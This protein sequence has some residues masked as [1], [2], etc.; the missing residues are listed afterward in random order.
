MPEKWIDDA[1]QRY[2][3]DPRVNG[4]DG[5]EAFCEAVASTLPIKTA[6]QVLR[7]KALVERVRKYL[8]LLDEHMK[9]REALAALRQKGLR[10]LEHGGDLSELEQQ[11][12]SRLANELQRLAE[13]ADMARVSVDSV[14]ERMTEEG[15]Q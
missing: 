1:Y 3:S 7:L 11:E 4:P 14:L 8:P 5:Y 15:E 2:D 9:V 10:R 12:Y 13:T 6:D